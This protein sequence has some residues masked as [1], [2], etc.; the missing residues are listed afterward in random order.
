VIQGFL[1]RAGLPDEIVAFAGCVLDGLSARFAATWRHALAPSD[2]A[3]DLKDFLRTDSRQHIQ[4]S[5][6]VIVLAALA[7]AHGFLTDRLRSSRIW[8]LRESDG[9]FTVQEIESTQRAILHDMDYGLFRISNAMVQQRLRNMQ[10]PSMSAVACTP[11]TV[12]KQD[13]R[14]NLSISLMGTAIWQFGAQTPEPS[15]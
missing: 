7:L 10:R 2:Y 14:R 11:N 15:P 13:R 8:S 9:A 4:L 3:R 5:P 1:D 6:D 12:A